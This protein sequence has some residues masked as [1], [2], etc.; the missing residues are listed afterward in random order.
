MPVTVGHV[1]TH[2]VKPYDN[3][4]YIGRPTPWGNPWVLGRHGGRADVVALF[5]TWWY[6]EINAPM[7]EAALREIPEN[8]VLG[9]WC[10]PKACHGDVIAEFLNRERAKVKDGRT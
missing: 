3:Y 1:H 10:M 9:C 8:A 6:S 2:S 4:V 7:R 5:R